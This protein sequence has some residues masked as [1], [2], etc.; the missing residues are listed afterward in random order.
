MATPIAVKN[1]EVSFYSPSLEK[2]KVAT[3]AVKN[4]DGNVDFS[5]EVNIGAITT[6]SSEDEFIDQFIVNWLSPN[7]DAEYEFAPQSLHITGSATTGF[8]SFFNEIDDVQFYNYHE[9]FAFDGFQVLPITEFFV[10]KKS[11]PTEV[12]EPSALFIFALG[13]MGLGLVR[14]RK[15]A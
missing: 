13:L 5:F 12:P 14:T 8:Q 9:G 1:Y 2:P 4:S 7:E 10:I 3:L 15:A 6:P 11:A